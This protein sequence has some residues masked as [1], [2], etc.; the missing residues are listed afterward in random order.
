MQW[1]RRSLIAGFVVIVPLV[2]SVAA[3]VWLFQF[4]DGVM[5]PVYVRLIGRE[6]PGFGLATLM[7][8]VVY[9]G[10]F[11]TNVLG[12][13]LLRRGEAYLMKLPVFR[14]IYSPV[15]QLVE[16]FSPDNQLGFKRV[17]LVD[18]PKRG[19]VLGFLTKEFTIEG[20]DEAGAHVAVYVP[21]NHV[22]FGDV[23][24]YP[25]TVVSYPSLTVQE[26]LQVFL[27]GGMALAGRLQIEQEK[28]QA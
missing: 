23:H 10:A 22:Y 5:G 11:A 1:L 6:I 17:V 15:K 7:L 14:G 24:I 3:F 28:R 16:A 2:I 9:V 20:Q 8:L 27:T 21:T 26:G 13:R 4:I 19:L 12:E 25:R 18:D